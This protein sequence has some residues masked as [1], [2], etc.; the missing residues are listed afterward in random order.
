MYLTSTIDHLFAGG[1]G[2]LSQEGHRSGIFKKRMQHPVA[3]TT[4][5]IAGDEH[6]DLRVHGGPEK[7]IHQFAV[8][9]Y[10]RLSRQFPEIAQALVPGSIG[11]NISASGLTEENVHIGDVFR[12]GTALLQVSQP[13]SPCWKINHRYGI[14][15]MSVFIAEE[16]ITGWYYRVL[17]EGTIAPEDTM[18]LIERETARISIDR[19]WR[20]Q[21]VH[22]PPIDD[23]LE[24]L[25]V[26]GLSGTWKER[27]ATRVRWLREQ[28]DH[29][30]A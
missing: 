14:D 12:I 27:L 28:Y 17:Q 7:A 23:L 24:I 21:S 4:S 30:A 6:A 26:P 16:R 18:E 25:D 11:E 10:G 2:I 20:I 19:F 13:R 8:E 9:N 22:R 29:P 5:G 15:R 3:V 1:I